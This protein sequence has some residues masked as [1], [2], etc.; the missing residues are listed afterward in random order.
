MV[1]QGD[2]LTEMAAHEEALNES[3]FFRIALKK[4]WLDGRTRQIDLPDDDVITIE[5]YVHFLYTQQVPEG[6]TLETLAS[7][8]S[9]DR[10]CST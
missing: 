3:P 6:M 7:S 8:M 5:Y 4:E 10:K 1:G 2:R 9:L